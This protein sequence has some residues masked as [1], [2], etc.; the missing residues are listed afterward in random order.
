M[1]TAQIAYNTR[2]SKGRIAPKAGYATDAKEAYRK[3][4]WDAILSTNPDPEGHM[5][6]LPSKEGLE[7]DHMVQRGIDPARIV[8]I[9]MNPAIIASAKWRDQ[10]PDAVKMGVTVG[11][12]W[13]RLRAKGIK[14][15]VANLDMC[16]T[17]NSNLV[18]QFTD[19][20]LNA[21][22]CGELTIAVTV[23]KGREESLIAALLKKNDC[24]PIFSC[25][26]L[27]SLIHLAGIADSPIWRLVPVA[28]G[29]YVS[30]R[31][32]MAWAVFTLR[33][34]CEYLDPILEATRPII[35]LL[36]KYVICEEGA[37][38]MAVVSLLAQLFVIKFAEVWPEAILAEEHYGHWMRRLPWEWQLEVQSPYNRNI[39]YPTDAIEIEWARYR[40]DHADGIE[41]ASRHWPKKPLIFGPRLHGAA[42]TWGG[43]VPIRHAH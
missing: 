24:A 21:P 27:N 7:I 20:V 41:V 37:R 3:A 36:T 30:G 43:K 9:D 16:A 15:S 32:P 17:V 38:N 31:H 22:R 11:K 13:E 12:A 1:A 28:E 10:Y 40:Q 34:W 35:K 4:V 25:P 14:V 6:V 23:A 5:L 8:G 2:A 33:P 18:Q 19:F 29:S 39:L 42:S 26:R